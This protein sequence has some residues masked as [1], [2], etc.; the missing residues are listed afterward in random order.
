M[1]GHKVGSSKTMVI[2]GWGVF[3][4]VQMYAV[5]RFYDDSVR[6]SNQQLD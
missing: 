4:Y 6:F 1:S 3:E 2:S 5:H